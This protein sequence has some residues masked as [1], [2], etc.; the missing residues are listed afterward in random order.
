MAE[1]GGL[2]AGAVGA[3]RAVRAHLGALSST[4]LEANGEVE[5]EATGPTAE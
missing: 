3:V 1:V 2:A 5:G 4:D